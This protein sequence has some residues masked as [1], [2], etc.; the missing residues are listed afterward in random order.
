MRSSL[1]L[2]L[3][4]PC[5]LEGRVTPEGVQAG[6]G[7]EAVRLGSQ[8]ALRVGVRRRRQG[9]GCAEAGPGLVHEGRARGSDGAGKR[10]MAPQDCPATAPRWP[11][12]S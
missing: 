11:F 8:R 6:S 7:A 10:L 3:S 2:R 5:A 4:L 1:R 9:R 12:N